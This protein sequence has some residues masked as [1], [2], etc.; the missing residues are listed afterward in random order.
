MI[1]R[2]ATVEDAV[3]IA[4]R[5]RPEDLDEIRRDHDTDVPK[6]L[7]YG[8]MASEEAYVYETEDGQVFA[9]GGVLRG[10]DG[11]G[12]VWQTG[13]PEIER[14]AKFYLRETRKL[15]RRF[16]RNYPRLHNM[17]GSRNTVSIRYLEH[18][19]Y[20]VEPEITVAGDRQVPYQYFWIGGEVN[21]QS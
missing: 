10:E 14:H 8:V 9:I 20:T 13:T 1:V 11:Y 21:V 18:L 19:G 4:P 6:I 17:V 16:L 3:H 5:L 12:I 7:V 2:P 15:M